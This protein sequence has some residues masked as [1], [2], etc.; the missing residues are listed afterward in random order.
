MY[1]A[2]PCAPLAGED[3]GFRCLLLFVYGL[4]AELILQAQISFPCN[5]MRPS[6][7]WVLVTACLAHSYLNVQRHEPTTLPTCRK[8]EQE[9]R[10]PP[11]A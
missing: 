3:F 2:I 9:R 5:P 6:T 7:H 1:Y 11:I 8:E 10:E 4:I